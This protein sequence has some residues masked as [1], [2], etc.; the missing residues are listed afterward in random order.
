MSKNL[1]SGMHWTS[2]TSRTYDCPVNGLPEGSPRLRSRVSHK[3]PQ[4]FLG[5]GLSS[6][7][8]SWATRTS[9]IPGSPERLVLPN[10]DIPQLFTSF[11]SQPVRRAQG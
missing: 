8:G 7:K 3:T 1:E 9:N 5:C 2:A 11:K 4:C 6:R 10:H